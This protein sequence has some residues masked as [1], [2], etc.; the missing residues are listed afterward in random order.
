M[1]ACLAVSL[2]AF[3]LCNSVAPSANFMLKVNVA[4]PDTCVVERALEW[5]PEALE[6]P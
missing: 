2:G 5:E 1:F 4:R 3:M 6:T